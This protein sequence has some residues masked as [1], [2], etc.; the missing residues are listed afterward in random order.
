MTLANGLVVQDLLIGKGI[1]PQPGDVC[2]VH[3]SLY[4]KG[5]EIESS[6]ESS[7]LAASPIGFQYGVEAGTGRS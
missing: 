7:G 1:T 5:D 6:R 4:Y 2:T 3:F